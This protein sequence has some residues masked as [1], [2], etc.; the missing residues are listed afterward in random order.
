MTCDYT[1]NIDNN[2]PNIKFK[3]FGTSTS[4]TD[5]GID[6]SCAILNTPCNDRKCDEGGIISQRIALIA[7]NN[8]YF[9]TTFKNIYREN[10]LGNNSNNHKLKAGGSFLT[11]F[12]SYCE[13][14]S[15]FSKIKD[16]KFPKCNNDINLQKTLLDKKS[17]MFRNRNNN[18]ISGPIIN[19]GKTSVNSAVLFGG[20]TGSG[21]TRNQQ[22]ANM[23]RGLLP[24][25][26]KGLR[27]GVQSLQGISLYSNSNIY[28]NA[29]KGFYGRT[30][31]AI[32][33]VDR[34]FANTN[35]NSLYIP[36]CPPP[37]PRPPLPASLYIDRGIELYYN[38]GVWVVVGEGSKK[39]LFSTYNGEIWQEPSYNTSTLP[40]NGVLSVYGYGNNWVVASW[41]AASILYST[42]NA[43][44]W[45]Y[46]TTGGNIFNAFGQSVVTNG[47]TWVMGGRQSGSGPTLVWSDDNGQN[48]SSQTGGNTISNNGFGVRKVYYNSQS[49]EPGTG[50]LAIG[51]IGAGSNTILYSSDGKNWTAAQGQ[52]SSD[53]YAA[54]NKV[55][56]D[57]W[58]AVGD[59]SSGNIKY[60][61]D[62]GKN[63]TD[64]QGADFSNWG[65]DVY[66]DSQTDIWV[67]VGWSGGGGTGNT[68]L[69]STNPANGWT[70]ANTQFYH[71][72][73]TVH[74][75]G[76]GKWVAG[77]QY[78]SNIAVAEINGG[79]TNMLYSTDGINWQPTS[80]QF[81]YLCN[82]IYYD[83]TNSRW[84]A[85]GRK[86][87]NNLN[88]N[89]VYW[90]NNGETWYT[91]S[92]PPEPKALTFINTGGE[93]FG[94][95]SYAIHK[96]GNTWIAVGRPFGTSDKILRSTNNGE[97][98]V[99]VSGTQIGF[100][101]IS[102][103]SDG[104]GTWVAVGTGTTF[105]SGGNTIVYSQDDGQTWAAVNTTTG[106]TFANAGNDVYYGGGT[107]VAVGRDITG[108]NNQILYSSDGETWQAGQN[109]TFSQE[110]QMVRY[111][112][113]TWVAVGIYDNTSINQNQIL[114]STNGQSWTVPNTVP[115][116]FR[117]GMGV[118][119]DGN[120]NWVAVGDTTSGTGAILYSSDSGTTWSLAVGAA[121][122]DRV[123]D[124]YYDGIGTWVAVGDDNGGNNSTVYSTDNG[125]TWTAATSA[126]FSSR[127]YSVYHTGSIW[128]SAGGWNKIYWSTNGINWIAANKP[129]GTNYQDRI[130]YDIYGD[131]TS[132]IAAGTPD[133]GTALLRG[134]F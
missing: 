31:S 13:N 109:N 89:T 17:Y 91:V 35:S 15:G 82:D 45:Q 24:N 67:A 114:T 108:N 30:V 87:G 23:G 128:V 88:Q 110:G 53:S 14:C 27:F 26:R 18:V 95:F 20:N 72:G 129:T 59:G 56:T 16:P 120:N 101:G 6:L 63:W 69:Y 83:S 73:N 62:N 36:I 29:P 43:Q 81:S 85:T 117:T 4:L 107:W 5:M 64:C 39:I 57:Y 113:T 2:N 7:Q 28:N 58:V 121:M 76:N 92:P 80:R 78:E 77:G 116:T 79:G 96:S 38:N 9:N 119:Y 61:T 102:V 54:Y 75:D 132:W 48:W 66:H 106:F 130:I 32:G 37:P 126:V 97:T 65:L 11:V 42:D 51:N 133:G 86:A 33:R 105:G 41:G 68:I 93:A 40:N 118:Y 74:S 99:S 49:Q 134:T 34:R 71:L 22:L 50:W 44:T 98:W 125:Q 21:L 131:G 127:G 115:I 25:G 47:T 55:G 90:S 123:Q 124:V 84:V 103:Y 19:Y 94:S 1:I 12:P 52:F 112:G 122:A 46:P 70:T 60:S 3:L 100:S 111:D 10:A 104:N 8:A